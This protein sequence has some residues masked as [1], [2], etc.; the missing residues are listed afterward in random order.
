MTLHQHPGSAV[1]NNGT[2]L[3]MTLPDET[4]DLPVHAYE[5]EAEEE[6][7]SMEEWA[8]RSL[9]ILAI[10]IVGGALSFLFFNYLLR[11]I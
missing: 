1:V 7:A 3:H 4:H 10:L 11:S 2:G 5:Q 8:M 9:C 6:F